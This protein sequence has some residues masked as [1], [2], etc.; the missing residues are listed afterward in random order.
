MTDN[1]A[2]GNALSE[3]GMT[4]LQKLI[5]RLGERCHAKRTSRCVRLHAE[6]PNEH[7]KYSAVIFMMSCIWIHPLT[8]IHVTK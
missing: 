1:T 5:H 3:R 6:Q 2:Y 8:S 4:P 7:I